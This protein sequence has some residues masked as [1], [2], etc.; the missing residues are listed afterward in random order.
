MHCLARKARKKTFFVRVASKLI[1][2]SI[3]LSFVR[4]I[5]CNRKK[6]DSGYI[7]RYDGIGSVALSSVL[8]LLVSESARLMAGAHV[9]TVF[10]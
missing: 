5:Q 2:V 6:D 4:A 7:W 1:M 8:P 10:L 9:E 3:N